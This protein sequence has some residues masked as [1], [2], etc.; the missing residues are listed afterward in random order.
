M[1]ALQ[2]F[3]NAEFGSVCSFMVNGE[4]YFVEG[5]VAKS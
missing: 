4:P 3:K 2:V 1:G 5:D